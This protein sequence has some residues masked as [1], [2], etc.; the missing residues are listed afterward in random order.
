MTKGDLV[1]ILLPVLERL[2]E[3]EV[4]YVLIG[5]ITVP[6]YL[7]E[8]LAENVRPTKDIDIIVAAVR[9]AQFDR[10]EEKLRRVGLKNHPE[11]RH[12]WLWEQTLIDIMPV[13]SDIMDTINRWYPAT[14]ETAEVIEIV[15]GQGAMIASPACFLATKME[16]FINRG[17]GD[18]LA[19]HDLEDMVAVIDGR[20]SLLDDIDKN[21]PLEVRE[22]LRASFRQL[23]ANEQFLDAVEGHLPPQHRDAARLDRLIETVKRLGQ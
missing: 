4:P 17:R 11:V 23:L 1:R 18:F 9:L 20:E 7:P 5:G 15:P 22:F 12:R 6:F 13:Q 10:I 14:F 8:T 19:S 21:C 2:N 3:T 16:A